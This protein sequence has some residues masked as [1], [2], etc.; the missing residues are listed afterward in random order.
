MARYR[1]ADKS[2]ETENIKNLTLSAMF[3]ALGFI[4]PF[5]TGQ[6]PQIGNMLL[7]MHLPVLLCGLIC[8]WKYGAAAGFVLP[9][10]RAVVFGMPPL[11]P[12][13]V[14]M[15]FELLTYGLIVG[16]VYGF[17]KKKGVFA[18]YASLITAMLTGRA[19]WGIVQTTLLGISGNTFTWQM[20]MT[21]AFVNAIP[22]IIAQLILIPVIMTALNR[23]EW[24]ENNG[25]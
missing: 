24:E 1:Y 17:F 16:L 13:A 18:V 19:V 5:L 10:F 3:I 7:P 9:L 12:T 22:G 2:I 25:K 23:R 20:F 4:L 11:F 21:G 14:S 8:G 15:S 6:I